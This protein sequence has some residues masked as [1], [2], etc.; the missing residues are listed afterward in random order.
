MNRINYYIIINIIASCFLLFNLYEK[1][2]S[3][4]FIIKTKRKKISVLYTVTLVLWVFMGIMS[5]SGYLGNKDIDIFGIVQGTFWT[6][7]C[8]SNLLG[9]SS[10]GITKGGIYSGDS[11]I[12]YFTKWSK[13]KNYSWI[14]DNIVQFEVFTR[15]NSIVSKEL[16]VNPEQ[17]EEVDKFLRENIK[18]IDKAS[19]KK[20]I[21]KLRMIILLIAII[22]AIGHINLIK[23]SKPYMTKEIKLEEDEAIAILQK[24]W[25]PLAELN[26]ENIK[27]REDFDKVFKETMSKSMI[28]D[29][30]RILV[31]T[32]KSTDEK[33]KFYENVR[34]PT[35]YDTK[36]S[37]KR[38]YI[39]SPKYKELNKEVNNEELTI[40][41]SGKLDKDGPISHFKRTSTFIKNDAGNWILDKISGL[42]SIGS[43]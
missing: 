37:I 18:K 13:I 28:E 19:N 22:M 1:I 12:S 15:K 8:I 11:N 40:E 35:I 34:I 2:Y 38:S 4:E 9:R 33:I 32:S 20:R 7:M 24:T 25:K 30:Y 27:S 43:Q 42:E 21:F 26:K 3:G 14:S 31:D 10:L 16:E 5:F 36:M 17:R 39:K 29:L 41:E 6:Q 23:A